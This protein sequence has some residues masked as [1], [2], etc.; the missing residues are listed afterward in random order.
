MLCLPLIQWSTRFLPTTPL[1]GVHID[2]KQPQFSLAS[3]KKSAFQPRFEN[4][5]LQNHGL[6]EPLV[7]IKN[8]I[9]FRLFRQLAS[10]YG[11]GHSFLAGTDH[12]I[13]QSLYLRDFNG[14]RNAQYRGV[15]KL[16]RNLKKIQR[17]M[18]SRGKAVVVVISPNKLTMYP[19]LVPA[20]YRADHSRGVRVIDQFLQAAEQ[21]ELDIFHTTPFLQAE[22]TKDPFPLFALP[23]AHWNSVATCAVA[24]EILRHA[25]KQ[26]GNTYHAID[27]SSVD[28]KPAPV[29]AD[30][31]LMD[32]INILSP[33]L[34]YRP[35]PYVEPKRIERNGATE[36]DVLFVGT[37]FIWGM[38]DMFEQAQA[39]SH[40]DF[41]YY[42]NTNHFWNADETD[43]KRRRGFHGVS[44]RQL[45]WEKNVFK[46][47][48]LIFEANEARLH[49]IGF[50]FAPI[51]VKEIQKRKD[52]DFKKKRKAA[53]R[54]KREQA[55]Q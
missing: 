2:R 32:A 30:H 9:D 4:W 37:S 24:N 35:T 51:M 22:D 39:Y 19:D 14:H 28:V 36:P 49:H 54:Q 47:D 52:P 5:F 11:T 44:Y 55:L 40:R 43:P 8:E 3:F 17:F 6:W 16:A 23:A 41:Y 27:C 50:K 1:H 26:S 53:K 46:K 42:A 21:V 13:F 31:D 18:N 45:R 25:E 10:Q 20:Q 29:G 48:I 33:E 15:L 38:L 12:S 34:S 7:R